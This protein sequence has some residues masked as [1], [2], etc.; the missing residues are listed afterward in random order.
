MAAIGWMLENKVQ[1][2][3]GGTLITEK[4]VLTAA[5]CVIPI[6]GVPPSIVRLGDTDLGNSQYDFEAQEF[7]ILRIKRHPQ[8]RFAQ[9]YHDLALIELNG[10]ARFTQEV[11]PACLWL[12]DE[13]PK[14]PLFIVGFGEKEF[15]GGPSDTLQQGQVSPMPLAECVGL[16]EIDRR[17]PNGLIE[18]QFC[19]SNPVMD[20]CQ[21]DSGGPIEV[22]R[23]DFADRQFPM[24]VGVTSFGTPCVNGSKGV[25]TKVSYYLDWIERETNESFSYDTCQNRCN[26]RQTGANAVGYE[27]MPGIVHLLINESADSFYN[28]TGAL[29]DDRFVL[30]SASCAKYLDKNASHIH[31][32]RREEIIQID[33][34]FIHPLYKTGN[35]SNDVALIK[36]SKYLEQNA[37]IKPVCLWNK[38]LPDNGSSKFVLKSNTHKD[39][40]PDKYFTKSFWGSDEHCLDQEAVN[41][42]CIENETPFIPSICDILPGGPILDSRDGYIPFLYGIVSHK[43]KGC[44][45]RLYGSRIRPH[46]DWIESIIFKMWLNDEYL[47]S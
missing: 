13:V 19:A 36:M 7:S 46:L 33:E 22:R 10:T 44:D 30:T 26:I 32:P 41:E 9:R 23:I 12:E 15:G 6:E 39:L 1:Y 16:F 2:L 11:C 40:R 3:C 14:G 27:T 47:F 4:F 24:V 18:S 8:H 34:I 29:I 28:C 25:Y 5:H 31:I 21:G 43:S 45:Q 17:I 38:D 42:L 35:L 37:T 20:T